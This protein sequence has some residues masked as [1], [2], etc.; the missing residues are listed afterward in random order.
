MARKIMAVECFDPPMKAALNPD[1][2]NLYE[3][4]SSDMLKGYS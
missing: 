3:P 2:E 1:D 4:L